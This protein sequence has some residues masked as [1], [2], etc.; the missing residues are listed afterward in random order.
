M[1]RK[2]KK[3]QPYKVIING[4]TMWQVNLKSISSED[5]NGKT[6]RIR[7]RRTF[8]SAQEANTFARQKAI[9]RENYS[10]DTRE[11]ERILAPFGVSILDAARDY[12]SRMEAS[13]RSESVKNAIAALLKA[14]QSNN[15]RPRYLKDLRIRLT[16]FSH[17]FGERRLSDIT[18]AEIDQWLRELAL[19]PL[20]RNTYRLRLNT[21]FEFARINKWIVAN[22]V[23]EVARAKVV[24]TLPGILSVEQAARLLESASSKTLPYH[25]L[26]LFCG[27]RTAE[28]ERLEWSNIHFDERL[29]EVPSLA[30]KTASRRFVSIRPNLAA[31]LEPF[32][33]RQE[34]ICPPNLNE[35]LVADRKAAGILDWPSNALRHSFAS[36]HLAAFRDA[37]ELALE[38]GHARVEIIFRHYHQ[39]VRPTEAHRYWQ[40]MPAGSPQISVVA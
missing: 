14:K 32:C 12:A 21:L 27:L 15:L 6:V 17:G 39:R 29:V 36:Y 34:K 23:T 11:A 31:W 38:M 24:D 7:P 37:K 20:G 10:G 18:P 40:I 13:L 28:L 25:A 9:E 35:R 3:F 22:P 33:K 19:A 8:S 2:R 5:A 1:A 30:S 26:G 16:R 4:Q